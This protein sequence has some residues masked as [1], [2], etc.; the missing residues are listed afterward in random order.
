MGDDEIGMGTGGIPCMIE[1]NRDDNEDDNED[2]NVGVLLC[3]DARRANLC[4][5]RLV[6]REPTESDGRLVD[7]GETDKKRVFRQ[8]LRETR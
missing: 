5:A 8:E 4:N 3:I 2:D 6:R 7:G 1:G